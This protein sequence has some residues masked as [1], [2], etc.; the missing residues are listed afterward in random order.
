MEIL[1][2][3]ACERERRELLATADRLFE[4]LAACV[5][6]AD[7]FELLI[8]PEPSTG[9]PQPLPTIHESTP[10]VPLPPSQSRRQEWTKEDDEHLLA[11][12]DQ[13]GARWRRIARASPTA[14]SDDALRN[15]VARLKQKMNTPP[16]AKRTRRDPE[17]APSR[18]SWTAEEDEVLLQ[19]IAES[20]DWR[21]IA[22]K[23]PPR[24]PHA[25]RNR[26]FRLL[27]SFG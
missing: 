15:R 1:A 3:C 9:G 24:T 2:D 19:A 12:F 27:G 10:V 7:P 16:A 22:R 14:R 6:D 11:L 13:C 26:C 5:P 17:E 21:A 8:M 18:L 23:L 25:C 4:A 20:H